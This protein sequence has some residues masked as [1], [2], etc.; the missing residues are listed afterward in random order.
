M[1]PDVIKSK[2][3][4]AEKIIHKL[5]VFIRNEQ[6]FSQD[7]Y[8]SATEPLIELENLLVYLRLLHRSEVVKMIENERNQLFQWAR[9]ASGQKSDDAMT[10]A[11][12]KGCTKGFAT[13]LVVVLRE[14]LAVDV[15]E[16]EAMQKNKEDSVAEK[17]TETEQKEIVEVKPGVFGI[18]V[19][20]KELARRLWKRVCSR[21]KD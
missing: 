4:I 15:F 20:I 12:A 18:T 5:E 21:S 7:Y 9:I 13:R 11:E 19:N 3:Q 16:T 10:I 8:I 2:M 1:S 17:A 14:A 6:A